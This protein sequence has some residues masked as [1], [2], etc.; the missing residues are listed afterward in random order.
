M[1]SKL[2][3]LVLATTFTIA[4]Y[5]E[6][7]RF[8]GDG[9]L[10]ISDGSHRIRIGDTSEPPDHC[11]TPPCVHAIQKRHGEYF[12]VITISHWTRGYPPKSGGGGCGAEAYIKWL[13]IVGGKIS[14]STEGRF[15]S[16]SDNREGGIDG[17]RGSI[18]KVTT[19]DL[20]E[21]RLEAK[22]KDVWQSIA[23]TFDAHHPENGIKE[24]K[25]KPHE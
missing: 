8:A 23:Y 12:V 10:V 25:G 4:A 9:T 19:D 21:D 5:G 13:H 20:L 1:K 17:W 15:Q 14:E 3:T 7:A 11:P 24:D 22:E 6:T 2:L 16:W 18:F